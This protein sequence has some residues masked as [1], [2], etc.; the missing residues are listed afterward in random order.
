[1]WW[2]ARPG[3][4]SPS[5]SRT[6]ATTEPCWWARSL[7][8]AQPAHRRTS[9]HPSRGKRRSVDVR[10]LTDETGVVEHLAVMAR[11]NHGFTKF[12]KIGLDKRGEPRTDDLRLVWPP[13]P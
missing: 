9:A 10:L 6:P 2:A 3:G 13:A 4:I 11:D 12:N 1:M 8:G 5:R 7:P